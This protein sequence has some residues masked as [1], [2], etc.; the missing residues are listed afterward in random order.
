MA[1]TPITVTQALNYEKNP[2]EIPPGASLAIFDTVENIN[3]LTA[4]D[5]SALPGIGVT[6]MTATDNGLVEI[7]G[8]DNGAAEDAA[9]SASKITITAEITAAA[10]IAFVPN[11]FVGPGAF[12]PM[13]EH[14]IVLDSAANLEA[15]SNGD[16]SR[17][18]SIIDTSL[19]TGGS[20]GVSAVTGIAATD[21]VPVFTANQIS[22]LG[23]ANVTVVAPPNDPSQ[24][25]GT[26]VISGPSGNGMTFDI[27]WEPAV[28]SAPAAFKTDVEEA[29]QFYA[30]TFNDPITLYYDVGFGGVGGDLGASGTNLVDEQYS[31]FQT[32]LAGDATSEAQ[33]TADA[34]LPATDPTGG[35]TLAMAAAEAQMLGFTNA[36]VINA[37]N[38]DGGIGFSDTKNFNYSADPNQTPVSGAY[39]F[40]GV[41]EHEISEVLGRRSLI[42]PAGPS[43]TTPFYSP[44][45]LFRYQG[46]N[47]RQLATGA[48]SYFSIDNGATN[49]GDWNNRQTGN[50]GDLGDW[51]GTTIGGSVVH[52]P[53]SYNDNTNPDVVNPVT[54]SDVTLMNVLGY[55]LAAPAPSPIPL[56]A[57]DVTITAGQL[58]T[59]LTFDQINPESVNPP[60]GDTYVVIDNAFDIE[61]LISS[62]I[63]AALAVG[64]GE[65]IVDGEVAVLQGGQ[66][67]A[68]SGTPFVAVLTAAEAAAQENLPQ[69]AAVPS[70]EAVIVS[71]TALNIAALTPAQ[72]A[73]FTVIGASAIEVAGN[74]IALTAPQAAALG[75]TKILLSQSGGG[76]VSLAV[77]GTAAEIGAL[78]PAEITALI[79]DGLSSVTTTTEP[80]LVLLT[81][82]QAVAFEGPDPSHGIGV[83]PGVG[84]QVALKD[85]A[86]NIEKLTLSQIQHL[87]VGEMIATDASVVFTLAQAF[88]VAAFS[89]AGSNVLVP[90]G[91]TV[92]IADTAANL[93][94]LGGT[95][96]ETVAPLDSANRIV[97][98]DGSVV[99]AVTTAEALE[100]TYIGTTIMI[101]VP[102]GD[103]VTLAD[104]AA[105]IESMSAAQLAAL[106][107]IGVTAVDVTDQSLTLTVAQALALIDPVPITVPPGATVIVADT[108]SAIDSLTPREVAA[109]A[110]IGVQE[111]EVSNLSGAGP[112]TIDGGITLSVTGAVPANET[113]TFAGSGGT[114]AP[115]DAADMAGTI[116]G[117]SPSDTIDLT[118]V[119]DDPSGAAQLGTDSSTGR[120]FIQVTANGNSYDLQ[121][122]PSQIF[123][124]TPTFELNPGKTTGTALTVGEPVFSG[125]AQVLSGETADGVVIGTGGEVGA[126]AGATVNRAV[127]ESGA[128]LLGDGGATVA[129]TTIDTGGLL[130]LTTASTGSGTINFGPPVAAPVGGTL[131]IDDTATL[132][133]TITN[134]AAGDM[135]DLTAIPSDLNGSAN[136]VQGTHLLDVNENG[137]TYALQLDQDFTG[138]YFHLTPD[139]GGTGTDITLL[140]LS[141][142]PDQIFLNALYEDILSRPI[143]PASLASLEAKMSAGETNEQIAY[144]VVSSKES[145]QDLVT[146][147]FQQFLGR[148][149]ISSELAEFQGDLSGGETE[150]Q[151]QANILGSPEFYQDAG[152]TDIGFVTALYQDLLG[153]PPSGAETNSWIE[154][155]QALETT[156]SDTDA[157][158]QVALDILNSSEHISDDLKG[159]FEK[160]L[161]RAPTPSEIATLTS[162]QKTAGDQTVVASILGSNEFFQDVATPCYAKGTL[163]QTARSQK[164]VERLKIGDKV[165]TKAGVTRPVKWIG[166]R[167]F[168]GRFVMGRK[169]ILPICV[170]AGALD[171]NV[172][173][174]DLW[175]SPHHAM[176]F[177]SSYFKSGHFKGSYVEGKN[178]NDT[179]REGAL[180][181]AK[182]LVNGV[183][184]V[185]SERVEKVEYFHVELETHDVILAEGALSETFLDDDSR[186]MF[187]NAG[188]FRTRY[189]QAAA[190]EQYC[191]PRLDEGYEL[192]AVRQHIALR[193]GLLRSADPHRVGPLHGH[194]DT[195]G[196]RAIEGWAQNSAA[197]EAPVCLDILVGG[198][199]VGQTL[200]NRFRKDLTAAGL[201]SGR[202][203]FKFDLPAGLAIGA[204]T[205]E[206][207]RSLDGGRLLGI[208]R[209]RSV[210]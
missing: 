86:A 152:N 87:R 45:D 207:H 181:E 107:S 27:T 60:S 55:G 154:Q 137:S 113:I 173:R 147:W 198:R 65:F 19:P 167:S 116:Y 145:Y 175:I 159:W 172:P 70:A 115:N 46:T 22:A 68:L 59:D 133:A 6:S 161:G 128:E 13:G 176:Y 48:P 98:T 37:D 42:Q 17:F 132:N 1:D 182:D 118:N 23:G 77:T 2:S 92:S 183:S 94:Q 53:D 97:S 28:A 151:V 33:K 50:S 85:T 131:E 185:Q 20:S 108:E 9:L 204:A 180:I 134:F 121:I 39:D 166:R 12:V 41:V 72:I 69:P 126:L 56:A 100:D 40:L 141:P 164:R 127:V 11:S 130:D 109:L 8:A 197:P 123:L 76:P 143:D 25:D 10:A 111:I 125:H 80:V 193:A 44:L 102:A 103:T 81:A 61:S 199:L 3:T 129:D 200:A 156:G 149:P 184:V 174:R 210:A 169:D 160:F 71:D 82:A 119:A 101:A 158:S 4:S 21:A 18:G 34:T 165:M 38:P 63:T 136:L 95:D 144:E 66:I 54:S 203:A 188:E 105:N 209:A 31:T 74:N 117:F 170:R 84:G 29:F 99:L 15:I 73:A 47:D 206:V 58:L 157:R 191:V 150:E 83:N 140:T 91:D 24:N 192:A 177:K 36:G 190:V 35:S 201:G 75:D 189:P 78:T 96:V 112:L 179:Y 104:A 135:I 142:S 208:S 178:F 168:G 138:E 43:G 30:D 51:A 16:L 195:V 124:T 14:V 7:T 52:T 89:E 93:D 67:L 163:I 194:V 122:D 153:R 155:I 114:L 186:G 146:S 26:T 57:T 62:E 205:V 139:S 120:Q 88:Y 162:F 106:T 148:A 5:I 171:D 196:P 187:H 202:H 79:A 32:Q 90:S 49:L 110:A 64:V